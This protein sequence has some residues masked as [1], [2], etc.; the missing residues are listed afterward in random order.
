MLP[1]EASVEDKEANEIHFV[2][3]VPDAAPPCD[4]AKNPAR[5]E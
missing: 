4:R 1:A 2:V 5:L 3:P